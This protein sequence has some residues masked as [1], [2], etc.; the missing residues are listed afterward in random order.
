MP[1]PF[2]NMDPYLE[3][4]EWP[5]FHG[6]FNFEMADR[7]TAL[8]RPHYSVR[9][10]Q[11]VYLDD[12]EGDEERVRIPDSVVFRS[13]RNDSSGGGTAVA[14]V[15]TP[16][17]CFTPQP[18]LRK[19]RYLVIRHLPDREAVTIIETLSP[20]NKRLGGTGRRHYLGKRDEILD[21]PTHLVEIDLLRGG[22][23]MPLG[24]AVPD[25]DHLVVVSREY[26]R[27]RCE[28][29]ANRLRDPLPRI[30]IPLKR[31][32]DDAPLDLQATVAEVYDRVGFDLTLDYSAEPPVP[33]SPDQ[34][35]W[36]RS[37]PGVTFGAS[38]GPQSLSEPA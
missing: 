24:G 11:R 13:L 33:F 17:I 32:D 4:P 36:A 22:G 8:L 19:E 6:R 35:E 3:G 34:R 9:A 27:P 15:A 14:G 16:A 30:P 2:P 10:E 12:E 20:A 29:Y 26:D 18:L 37:L 23:R 28:V 31:G 5:T 25:A 21:G 38:D 7:L 1:S